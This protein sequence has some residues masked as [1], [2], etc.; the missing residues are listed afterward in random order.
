MAFSGIE[1]NAITMLKASDW[2]THSDHIQAHFFHLNII[3]V[4]L[5][6]G[7]DPTSISL[8][9]TETLLQP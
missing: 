1:N 5:T 9:G 2:T 7:Y 3:R 8:I 4:I 6:N